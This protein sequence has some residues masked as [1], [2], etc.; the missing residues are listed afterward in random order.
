MFKIFLLNEIDQF[1]IVPKI[2][3]GD[4]YRVS[5]EF[6]RPPMHELIVQLALGTMP[7]PGRVD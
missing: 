1:L 4:Y 7:G 3:G 2:W 6:G 5:S